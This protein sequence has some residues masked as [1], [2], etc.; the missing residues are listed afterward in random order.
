MRQRASLTIFR[1]GLIFCLEMFVRI[2]LVFIAVLFVIFAICF[3]G[4]FAFFSWIMHKHPRPTRLR[5]GDFEVDKRTMRK[6]Y[7]KECEKNRAKISVQDRRDFDAHYE[8]PR[9]WYDF[10]DD[11]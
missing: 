7:L 4:P 11:E 5:W 2:Y 1:N 8:G 3:I 10:G 6:E 9:D